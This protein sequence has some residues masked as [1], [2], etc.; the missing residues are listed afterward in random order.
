KTTDTL[1]S[2]VKE[3]NEHPSPR[4]LDM[5][6]TT[7]E[8]ISISLLSVALHQLNLEARSFTG[9]QAGIVT[10]DFHGKA[11]ISRVKADK[12]LSSLKKGEVAVV[13]GFQGVT[14]KGEITTLGRGGSDTTA[15]TLAA[16]LN[17]EYCEIYTDVTGVYT[18]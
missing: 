8:Q 16:A 12:L 5:L 11:V 1:I 17:A 10:D 2:L 4:E 14:D 18:A 15:V 7:G 13:A 3:L 9:W 6:L